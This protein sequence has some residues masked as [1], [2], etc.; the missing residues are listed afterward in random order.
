MEALGF[1]G[2]LRFDFEAGARAAL[3][4]CGGAPLEA[5]THQRA[6]MCDLVREILPGGRNPR[7][8]M[9]VL[10]AREIGGKENGMQNGRRVSRRVLLGAAVSLLAG[11][12]LAEG[13][14][15]AGPLTQMRSLKDGWQVLALAFSPDGKLLATGNADQTAK[16]RDG[17]S[18]ELVRTLPAEPGVGAH[19][20][21]V[22]FTPDGRQLISL[23]GGELKVWDADAGALRRTITR[24]GETGGRLMCLAVSPDGKLVAAGGS[25]W[26]S[27]FYRYPSGKVG[28]NPALVWLWDLPTGAL[29][30]V[31]QQEEGGEA[32]SLAFSPD[33]KLLAS[34]SQAG[35]VQLWN[36]GDFSARAS[37]NAHGGPVWALAFSPGGK[38][39]ASGGADHLIAVWD[40]RTGAQRHTL[41]GHDHLVLSLVYSPDGKRLA[42][43]SY[44]QTLKLWNPEKETEE[45][46]V[47]LDGW[48][49]SLAFSPDGKRLA[50]GLHSEGSALRLWEISPAP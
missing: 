15:V 25:A 23:A 40:A 36:T 9:G 35:A 42:S 19:V 29:R 22:A 33:G 20:Q 3:Q 45:Q 38:S 44:D 18:G 2:E 8:S 10:T 24:G 14:G 6:L 13:A 12:G 7:T 5:W 32:V 28:I 39:L 4:A 50:A 49:H 37:L 21:G 47:K 43:G 48:V 11:H 16:L 27:G 17:T 46:T 34:G 41:R 30:T 1:W 31:L 26:L